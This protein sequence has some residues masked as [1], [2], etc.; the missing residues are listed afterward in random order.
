MGSEGSQDVTSNGADDAGVINGFIQHFMHEA[1]VEEKEEDELQQ[2]Q[3]QHH[4]P[5]PPP[6]H[7][8][9][10]DELMARSCDAGAAPM[11][12]SHAAY[13]SGDVVALACFATAEATGAL[14][15]CVTHGDVLHSSE[16]ATLPCLKEAGQPEQDNEAEDLGDDADVAMEDAGK[17]SLPPHDSLKQPGGET[18]ESAGSEDTEDAV[19]DSNEVSVMSALFLSSASYSELLPHSTTVVVPCHAMPLQ[20][21]NY[22]FCKIGV[23]TD[24]G[25][26][27]WIC[28]A[29]RCC[30]ELR[31][32]QG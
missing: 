24:G 4:S 19:S 8:D 31:A 5:S 18:M 28:Q 30:R 21:S 1:V 32:S 10:H 16:R 20:C 14:I 23:L 22:C 3:Q 7:T 9:E 26:P 12:G 6:A 25:R 15:T 13:A 11:N 27:E 2:Q 29:G 17:Q